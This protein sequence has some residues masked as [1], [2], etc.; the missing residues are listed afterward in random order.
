[1]GGGTGCGLSG[2]AWLRTGRGQKVLR[3]SEDA[4]LRG[5][6]AGKAIRAEESNSVT[7]G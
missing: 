5:S 1:M 2:G 6:Q 3:V 4:Q 7:V